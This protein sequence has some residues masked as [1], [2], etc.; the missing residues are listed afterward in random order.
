MTIDEVV[1][2]LRAFEKGRPLPFGEKLRVPRIDDAQVLSLAFLKMGGE[3]A[4]WG[5]A[6][7]RPGKTPK[8]LTVAEARTRDAVADIMLEL[9]PVLLTH[10]HHPQFSPFGPDPE[11]RLPPFQIWLPND[12][13]LEMLHH[14]AYA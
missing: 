6:Y 2:R 3:S 7:G 4:P 1:R 13:H 14:I 8:V 11:T 12:T 5:V 10:V 9:A